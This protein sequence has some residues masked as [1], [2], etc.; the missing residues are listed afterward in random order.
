MGCSGGRARLPHCDATFGLAAVARVAWLDLLYT[1]QMDAAMTAQPRVGAI[2]SRSAAFRSKR[3]RPMNSGD[4]SKVLRDTFSVDDRSDWSPHGSGGAWRRRQI[5][6]ILKRHGVEPVYMERP[7][8]VP[9]SLRL[10]RALRWKF[11]LGAVLRWNRRSLGAAEYSFR[12]CQHNARRPG[13]SRVVLLESG[14]DPVAIATLKDEGFRVIAAL[15]AI[16][17]LWLGRPSGLTGSYPQMFIAEVKALANADAVFCIS[18]EEQWLLNNLKV[19]SEYLPYFPDR[20]RAAALKQERNTRLQGLQR[21][22]QEF[23]ICATRG[24]TDTSESFREQAAWLC[25]ADP[26]GRA[27]F[28]VTGSQSEEL[29]EIWSDSR[30]VF[31]GTC[32]DDDFSDIKRRSVAI[33]IHQRQGL[34]SLTRIPDMLLSGV[35]IIANGTAARSF[36]G[37]DGV[38]VYETVAQLR[39]LLSKDIPVPPAPERPVELE[40][41]FVAALF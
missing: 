34:G 28:H 24:N 30:F 15:S 25:Q 31:H 9:C 23:L 39:D 40:D 32:S 37:V 29:R 18:R 7:P 36:F 41:A 2:Y 1:L 21:E 8:S 33:C 4:L 17:S 11:R 38:Y 20:Q 19:R 35:A 22:R 12:Y 26:N 16:N 3:F 10:L 6:D 14:A 13:L 5:D 27:I